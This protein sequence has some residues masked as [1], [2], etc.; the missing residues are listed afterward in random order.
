[1]K[2]F[3]PYWLLHEPNKSQGFATLD[4]EKAGTPEEAVKVWRD[5]NREEWRGI[6]D[7]DNEPMEAR[8]IVRPFQPKG[9]TP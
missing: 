6:V 7:W 1:M 4:L 9:G 8:L 2:D 3:K 5:E